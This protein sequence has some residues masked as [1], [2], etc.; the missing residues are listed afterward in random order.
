MVFPE[1]DA[2]MV[3]LL[4]SGPSYQCAA[5]SCQLADL[6]TGVRLSYQRVTFLVDVRVLFR[7]RRGAASSSLPQ[8]AVMFVAMP[9]LEEIDDI[10]TV[11]DLR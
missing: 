5:I 11:G 2:L 7:R 6:P 8:R 3:I 10:E 9:D 1:L 4:I